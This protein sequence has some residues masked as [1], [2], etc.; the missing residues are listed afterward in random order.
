MSRLLLILLLGYFLVSDQD[1][2]R[3]MSPE[4]GAA[5]RPGEISIIAVAQGG[6]LFLDNEQLSV[7]QPFPDV[8]GD[9]ITPT[10]GKHRLTLA[11]ANGKSEIS[12]FVG[13]NPPEG[14]KPFRQ[15]PPS[16]VEC[17]QCH[18]LSRKGRLRFTGGCFGCHEQS[19]FSKTHSHQPPILEQC[20]QCHAAH[21]STT[22]AHLIL[23]REK[24]CGL[25]HTTPSQ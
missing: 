17:V 16:A 10:P 21:G 5:L 7:K 2:C 12:F 4:D 6:K 13:D 11:W 19:S 14:F 1:D 8:L 18:S 9:K 23:T 24:A 20:G 25:C 3:I 15:H 22:K